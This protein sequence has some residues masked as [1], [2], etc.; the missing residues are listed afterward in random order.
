MGGYPISI[1]TFRTPASMVRPPDCCFVPPAKRNPGRIRAVHSANI[2][3]HNFIVSSSLNQ[4]NTGQVYRVRFL[5]VNEKEKK[6]MEPSKAA[7]F[8]LLRGL[9]SRVIDLSCVPV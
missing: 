9:V 2:N 7:E 6:V 4:K 8:Q 1:P 3:F 5:P